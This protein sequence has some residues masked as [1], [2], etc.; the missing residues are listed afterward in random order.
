ML[1]K[2][3]DMGQLDNTIIVF[4]TDNGAESQTFPDGGMTPFKAN[5]LTTWEGGM[6]V[7]MVI[8]W[9]GHI[10]PGTLKTE[11]FASSTGCR[12]FVDIAGGPKGNDLK[13]QIEKGAISRHRQ[14]DARRREPTR[15]P[16]RQVG[17][18]GA[19]HLL[20]LHR[21]DA[22]GG[23][24]QELE[25]LLHDGGIERCRLR[26]WGP[27]TFGWA[28]V[29]NIKRDPFEQAVGEDQKSVL[30]I[31]GALAAPSTAYLYNWNML[32]VGQQLWLKELSVLHRVPAA[33][34]SGELQPHAGAGAGQEDGKKPERI[35]GRLRC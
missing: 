20:L 22:V 34:G 24:V 27:Q 29:Q 4:T 30:S 11:I 7:P 14:D 10:K 13:T 8:R 21:G 1:K 6:R 25:D 23:A 15:L 33:A 9:P 16:R 2:L 19:R 26:S 5:K 31:G 12:R 3:E 28:Q 18:V 35:I 17:E 32:P